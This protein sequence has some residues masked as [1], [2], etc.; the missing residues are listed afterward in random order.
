[1]LSRFVSRRPYRAA[2]ISLLATALVCALWADTAAAQS[3]TTVLI[4]EATGNPS[5]PYVE[6]RVSQSDLSNYSAGEGDIIPAPAGGCPTAAGSVAPTETSATTSSTASTTTATTTSSA[7]T[8]ASTTSAAHHKK[9]TT[10]SS[11][12]Q[13]SS[14]SS[15]APTNPALT[16]STTSSAELTPEVVSATSLPRT[17]GQV[18]LTLGLGLLAL[19]GGVGAALGPDAGPPGAAGTLA[20]PPPPPSNRTKTRQSWRAAVRALA[21]EG[22][23]A[24]ARRYNE[25]RW[26]SAETAVPASPPA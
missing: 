1:M 3:S 11:G 21:P 4:C 2:L 25:A 14:T 24:P 5:A 8:S 17:G 13:A 22:P 7:S 16:T 6:I 12:T 15:L 23:R 9:H 18:P 10:A 20:S 19:I 26:M